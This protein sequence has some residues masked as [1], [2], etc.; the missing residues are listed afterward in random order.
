MTETKKATAG[1]KQRKNLVYL[2]DGGPDNTAQ[3]ADR[4]PKKPPRKSTVKK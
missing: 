2:G 4:G 3:P 1:R